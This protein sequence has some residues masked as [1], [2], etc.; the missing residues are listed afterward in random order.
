MG[1]PPR[2]SG[3]VA[4]THGKGRKDGGGR[5]CQRGST[6]GEIDGS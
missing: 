4:V 3:L 2:I 6:T 5:S 1:V